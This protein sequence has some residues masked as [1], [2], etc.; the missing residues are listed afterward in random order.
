MS[1]AKTAEPIDFPFVLWTWVERRN[2]EA[3]VQSYSPGGAN[4]PSWEGTLA[5]AAA[6]TIEPS[7]CCGD[8]ALCQITL[9]TCYYIGLCTVPHLTMHIDYTCKELEGSRGF[10][11]VKE[12]CCSSF[13]DLSS[14]LFFFTE[15]AA[16]AIEIRFL[17]FITLI[18]DVCTSIS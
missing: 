4:V 16:D 5:P 13:H 8:A 10:Q 11:M 9:T 17:L 14:F 18:F 2:L 15:D 12:H 1:C 7:V 3:R 6:N